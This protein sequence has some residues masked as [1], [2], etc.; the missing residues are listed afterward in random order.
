PHPAPG[1]YPRGERLRRGHR[2]G[3]GHRPADRRSGAP[4]LRHPE[5]PGRHRPQVKDLRH[6]CKRLWRFGLLSAN[7]PGVWSD[8]SEFFS[9]RWRISPLNSTSLYRVL[10]RRAGP[11]GLHHPF[12]EKV[13]MDPLPTANPNDTLILFQAVDRREGN[14]FECNDMRPI[15]MLIRPNFQ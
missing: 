15:R 9:R 4:T 12:A 13:N 8:G 3:L 5:P 2:A 11:A 6:L 1:R 14:R 7:Y 10:T